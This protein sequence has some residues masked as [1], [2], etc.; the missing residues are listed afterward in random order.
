ML[1]MLS[2]LLL[3]IGG[4]T[5]WLSGYTASQQALDALH[6]GN[7]VTVTST[8]SDITFM[9]QQQ[10]TVGLIFYPGARVQPEAY[11]HYMRVFA[12][13][14]YAAFI[15]RVP[16]DVALLGT[17]LAS[18]IIVAHPDIKQWVVGGHSLGGVSACTFALQNTAVKGLLLYA[19]YP[20]DDLSKETRLHITSISGSNDG[21]ATPAKVDA[22]KPR[23]PSSTKYVVVQGGVHA[24]F[25][26]YGPQ[27][28]DGQPSISREAAQSMIVDASLVLLDSVKG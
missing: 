7:G 11:A 10:P 5:I 16:F 18:N 9:P 23:L 27:D 14:G 8:T 22:A 25:G 19:S 12:E 6:S 3:A 26:D 28:G 20:N 2:V 15:L 17:D 21:L 4:A 24:F 13:H 1:S